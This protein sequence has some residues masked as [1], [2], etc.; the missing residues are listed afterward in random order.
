MNSEWGFRIPF[1]LQW[2]WPVPLFIVTAFAPESPWHLVRKGRLDEARAVLRR[3]RNPKVP[4]RCSVDETLAMMEY[5]TRIERESQEGGASWSQLFRGHDRRRTE[6][7]CCAWATQAM[8]GSAFMG[9][10]TYFFQRAGMKIQDSFNLNLAQYIIGIMGTVASWWIMSYVGRRKIFVVG[11]A[12]MVP[13]LV[14]IG[15]LGYFTHVQGISW[16]VGGLVSGASKGAK[17]CPAIVSICC[18]PTDSA[19]R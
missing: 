16:A 17:S 19:R 9:F 14:A 12:S 3:I 5:T 15:V 2:C 8:C 4:A 7:A 1:A 6:I 13:V 11:L 18:I 10:G